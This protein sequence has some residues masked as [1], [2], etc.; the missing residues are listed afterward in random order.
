VDAERVQYSPYVDQGTRSTRD[1]PVVKTQLRTVTYE[2]PQGDDPFSTEMLVSAQSHSS[3][4]STIETTTVGPSQLLQLALELIR[5]SNPVLNYHDP[6][7]RT[8]LASR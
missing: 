8:D 2:D 7:T 3:R 6:H 5:F 1:V 4:S